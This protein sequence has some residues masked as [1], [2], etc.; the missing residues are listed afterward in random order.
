MNDDAPPAPPT[1]DALPDP[2]PGKTGWPWT[3]APPTSPDTSRPDEDPAISIV[4]PSYNQGAF[5]EETIRSVLLQGYPNLEYVVIDGGSTDE[6]V[7]II[8]RYAPWIDYWESTS[9][10]GQSHAINKGFDRVDGTIYAWLN[11]DDVYL[12]GAFPTVAQAFADRPEAG[13]L[14]GIGERVTLDG[15]VFYTPVPDELGFDAFLDWHNNDFL[16]PACFFRQEAWDVGGPL[17]EDLYICLDVDLWLRMAQNGVSFEPLDERLA[18]AKAHSEAKTS[19]ELERM[20]AETAL[21]VHDYGATD[22][23]RRMMMELADDLADA[24]QQLNRLR[25]DRA[26][27]WAK[28]VKD[29]AKSILGRS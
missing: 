22:V 5:L 7:S 11:S 3:E 9:D 23:S 19:V 13:A 18:Q 12:P 10:R 25:N 4:T 26:V 20:R 2:P 21:L 17:R 24:R 8:E 29:T 6:S 16:Q 15:E 14:V 1:L 28:W 27:Q